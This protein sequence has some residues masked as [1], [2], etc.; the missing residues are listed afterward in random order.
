MSEW[1]NVK[2]RLPEPGQIVLVYQIYSWARF[3]E[4][5]A[6]TIGRICPSNH[7]HWEFQHYRPDFRNGTVIDND[8]IC[9]G[10]EYVTHWMPLPEPPDTLEAEQTKQ[11]FHEV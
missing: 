7:P 4:G 8:I 6:V 11:T 1:I 5:A 2:D 3:E 10:S 9:P